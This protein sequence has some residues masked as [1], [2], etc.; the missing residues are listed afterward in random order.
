M[1]SELAGRDFFEHSAAIHGSAQHTAELETVGPRADGAH[2][3]GEADCD[4]RL[5]RLRWTPLSVAIAVSIYMP[6]LPNIV[7]ITP[8]LFTIPPTVQLEH[9]EIIN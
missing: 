4:T 1:Q 6:F 5:L 9:D 7:W 2:C 8:V 3:A